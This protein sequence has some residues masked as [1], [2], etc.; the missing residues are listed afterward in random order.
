MNRLALLLT[1]L[2]LASPAALAQSVTELLRNGPNAEKYNIVIIGD[3]F[4][5]ADQTAYNDFVRDTV[6]RDLLSESRDGAYRE[7]TDSFNIFRVNADSTQS[8]ITTVDANGQVTNAVTTF[9]DFRFSGNWSLLDG[10]GAELERHAHLHPEQPRP[11]MGLR[12]RGTQHPVIW[13]L[14]QRQPA[15]HH[16]RCVLDRRRSRDGSHDREPRR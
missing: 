2:F 10:T 15:G 14:S 7:I 1:A 6:I 8:G 16:H 11:R 4:A 9:L 5:S 13:R 12:V 3:G